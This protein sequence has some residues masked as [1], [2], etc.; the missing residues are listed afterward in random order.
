M[1]YLRSCDFSFDALNFQHVSTNAKEFISD[2]L[3][4]DP[5]VT[6]LTDPDSIH[7]GLPDQGSQNHGQF[8][9]KSTKITRNMILK[10]YTFVL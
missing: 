5:E 8:T 6:F 9:K 2:L 1:F 7:F 4:L 3:V 10:N